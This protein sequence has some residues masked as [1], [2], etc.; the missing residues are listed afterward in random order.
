MLR[1]SFCPPKRKE[2]TM[3]YNKTKFPNIFSY[4]TKRGIRYRI[5]RGYF[6]NGIKKEIDESGFK[7]LNVELV[8]MV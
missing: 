4:Q 6:S 2:N 5:R 1:F 3:K 8:R 7:T